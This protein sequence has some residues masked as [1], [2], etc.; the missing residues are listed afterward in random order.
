M[1]S[2]DIQSRPFS[3]WRSEPPC[4]LVYDLQSRISRLD[5]HSYCFSLALRATM[6]SQSWRSESSFSAWRSE[7]PCFLVYD[8]PSYQFTVGRLEP[9]FSYN[10][11]FRF[12]ISSFWRSEPPLQFG[13]QSRHLSLVQHSELSRHF[14]IRHLEPHFCFGVQSHHSFSIWCLEPLIIFCLALRA[15]CSF[16]RSES[17]FILCLAFRAAL[18]S[19]HSEPYLQFGVQCHTFSSTFRAAWSSWHSELYLHFG[20]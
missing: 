17:S 7:P 9:P 14:S 12:T 2:Y 16:W 3:A 5:F 8:I 6:S 10:S 18:S 19:W 1:L 4:L 20:V 11:T 15:T 13:V